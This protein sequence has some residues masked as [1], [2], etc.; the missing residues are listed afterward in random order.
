[1]TG[2]RISTHPA[3]DQPLPV[4]YAVIG[5]PVAHSKSPAIHA[6]FAAACGQA[7][8]YEALLAPLDGF[9]ACVQQ[10]RES[11]GLGANVTLPFKVEAFELASQL[12]PRAQAAGAV[13]TLCFDG[14]HI[15][16]DNTD[17][18]GLVIDIR[19]NAQFDIAG[20]RVLLLGA[21]GAARGAVLP[22]LQQHPSQI[23]IANRTLANAQALVR[24]CASLGQNQNQN[25]NQSQPAIEACS[26]EALSGRF[27]L[28]INASSASLQAS[29]P[30]LSLQ[31]LDQ[32]TLAY[33]MMYAARPTVF[34]QWASQTGA[35]VRDGLGMLVEQAAQAFELW[36][37][38]KP[39]TAAV[40]TAL[41]GELT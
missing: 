17:G 37:G 15:L 22:L 13:N 18:I 32:A 30:P 8:K 25:Q 29:L 4:R 40:Y 21:G 12:S 1:M 34:M 2:T 31:L 5:N 35:S 23:V 9:R 36:R 3:A 10:F 28:I 24:Q 27:D 7:M 33:D 14:G 6:R 20:K 19:E 26:F 16:G 41:R 38:V 11:G 39:D